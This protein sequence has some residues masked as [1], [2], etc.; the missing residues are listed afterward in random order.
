MRSPNWPRSAPQPGE[1]EELAALRAN[2]QKGA[3]LAEDIAAARSCSTGSEGG[4]S[5]LRQSAR[6][7]DRIAGEHD[8]LAEAL[9]AIDRAVI[10]ASEAEDRLDEAAEALAFDP[11]RL[12]EAETRLF[13]LRA[14]ARKHRVE[15]DALAALAAELAARLGAIE[16]GERGTGGA[17]G[18]VRDEPRRL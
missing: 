9:A 3:R 11:A 1:E 7:L 18:T 10:E 16:A 2:M 8:K 12:E 15:P 5:Q 6:R 14:L 17:G 13:E 4:L